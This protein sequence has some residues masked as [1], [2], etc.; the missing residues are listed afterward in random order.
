LVISGRRRK[1]DDWQTTHDAGSIMHDGFF[2]FPDPV[3]RVFMQGV[4]RGN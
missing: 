2:M 1:S 4:V 3:I